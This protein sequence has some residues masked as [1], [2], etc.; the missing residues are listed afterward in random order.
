MVLEEYTGILVFFGL[1]MFL[2]PTI[3]F[4]SYVIVPK[5]HDL[6]KVSAYECGFDPFGEARSP[7][8]VKFYLVALLFI[9]FDLEISFLFPWAVSL[10]FLD[11]F[12][13]F[14]MA[15]FLFVLTLGFLY[16]WAKGALDWD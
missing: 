12:G 1:A 5:G 10:P 3:F 8:N 13:F 7:F 4:L 16:E 15:I 2:S 14:T 6:E 9:I 11:S